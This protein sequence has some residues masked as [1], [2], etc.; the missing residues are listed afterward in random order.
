MNL[1]ALA[2]VLAGLA[3]LAHLCARAGRWHPVIGRTF[4]GA[5]VVVTVCVLTAAW[6]GPGVP[7]LTVTGAVVPLALVGAA[8]DRASR[9]R[10]PGA[11]QQHRDRLRLLDAALGAS[12][13]GV[14][15][16]AARPTVV[17]LQIVYANPAFERLTGYGIDEALGQSPS[18]LYAEDCEADREKVRAA[19][20]SDAPGRFEVPARRKDGTEV[21]VE[22]D[23]VP[24]PGPPDGCEYRV[25]VLRDTT[26]RRRL[27]EQLRNAAKL[28]AVG[29]LA[30]GV[31]HD[32][33][34]LLTVIGGS[35]ALLDGPAGRGPNAARL[36]GE[37]R[38]A[39][40]RGQWLVRQLLT[41]ARPQAA[42]REPLDLGRVA[43]D[44]APILA[45]VVGPAIETDVDTPAEPVFVLADRG[46][47][48]QALLNL[49]TNARDAMPGGGRLALRVRAGADWVRVAVTDTGSGMP[50]EVR[51]RIFEPFF[52][53][54]GP[55]VGTGLG[56][57]TVK[58]VAE[59]CGG[60]IAVESAP[61]RG[62]TFDID[63][64]R[65]PAPAPAPTGTSRTVLLAEDEP[66]VRAL[67]RL[68]LQ[69]Q[70]YNVT[71]AADGAEALKLLEGGGA[72]DLLV[73]DVR[74]PGA[75]GGRVA[76]RA[77]ELL[78]AVRVVFMSGFTDTE[79][80]VPGSVF[81][82]KP[83]PP[84]ALARATQHARSP[85]N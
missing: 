41:F 22:W 70:G 19:L 49:A 78:P 25:A 65:C 75:D 44:L 40:E 53:T 27:E 32:F 28:E 39:A 35:A 80:A 73:T 6:A 48:E 79:P 20:R 38:F 56:L 71:E 23:V 11:D 62:T 24:V 66:G 54:K 10:R 61:G 51:E 5:S 13:D 18:M 74:M 64:P 12:R 30:A 81:L 37:V 55:D 9:E 50:P 77:R 69:G 85:H 4:R 29:R 34:N 84:A 17:G 8:F 16:T 36:V 43:S 59:R 45:R 31:A 60:R 52:T 58:Q 67:A 68:I 72:F 14:L 46:E 21:C 47:L 1:S 2:L 83:F 82:P 76:A 57:T 33:N 15:V 3:P 42:G 26:E 63:L 7:Y